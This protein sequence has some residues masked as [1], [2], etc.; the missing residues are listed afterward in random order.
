MRKSHSESQR[1]DREQI[2]QWEIES[3]FLEGLNLKQIVGKDEL[4][5]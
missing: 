4:K 2:T 3:Q 5:N 1:N